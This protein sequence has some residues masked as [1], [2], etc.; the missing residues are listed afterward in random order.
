[1]RLKH[2]M[3]KVGK[4][5][6]VSKLISSFVCVLAGNTHTDNKTTADKNIMLFMTIKRQI[7]FL[8]PNSLNYSVAV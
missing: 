1:M 5:Q 4:V 6:H 2:G 3:G 7:C 8:C